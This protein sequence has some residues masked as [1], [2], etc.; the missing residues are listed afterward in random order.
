MEHSSLFLLLICNLLQPGETQLSPS[1]HPLFLNLIVQFQ[2]MVSGSRTVHWCS[3][4]KQLHQL[5]YSPASPHFPS[6]SGQRLILPI[7]SAKLVQYFPIR[8]F[9]C[10][11]CS[12]LGFLTPKWFSKIVWYQGVW[13]LTNTSVFY[14][15]LWSFISWFHL[16]K[17]S[18]VLPL[19]NPQHPQHPQQLLVY[20]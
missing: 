13:I 3:H 1:A 6:D 17:N 5:G 10:I 2:Y 8:F 20:L 15:L 14:P 12:F 11:L 4:G 16:P 19:F 9:R 18:P 7:P